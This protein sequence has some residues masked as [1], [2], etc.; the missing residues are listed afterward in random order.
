MPPDDTAI[1][2]VANPCI[3]TCIRVCLA[4]GWR[5]WRASLRNPV[6]MYANVEKAQ[7]LLRGKK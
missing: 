6:Y 7:A 5:L 1:G 4:R 2:G 3:M